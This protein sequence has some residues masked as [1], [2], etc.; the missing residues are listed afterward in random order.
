MVPIGFYQNYSRV[1]T[2][3]PSGYHYG[4]ARHSRAPD[5][6]IGYTQDHRTK[7]ANDGW[8][9]PDSYRPTDSQLM[10]RK[11]RAGGRL[12]T[13]PNVDGEVHQTENRWGTPRKRALFG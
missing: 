13:R 10:G 12:A 7:W 8:V 9:E 6:G 1:T 5:S 4:D 3:T 11:G 2:P